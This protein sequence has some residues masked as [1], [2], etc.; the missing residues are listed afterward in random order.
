MNAS[1]AA[2]TTAIQIGTDDG[3]TLGADLTTPSHDPVGL[4]V[5]AHPHPL[6]G[7]NRFSPVVTAVFESLGAAGFAVIRF[8]FRGV[9][10]STGTHG[11]GVGERLDV[12]SVISD[13]ARRHPGVALVS[14]G[15]SFGARVALT[16]DHPAVVAWATVAPPLAVAPP[17][18]E[19]AAIGADQ[20][21]KLLIV[22]EQ[23]QFSPPDATSSAV[24]TWRA[25]EMVVSEGSDHF[26]HHDRARI[27]TAADLVTRFALRHTADRTPS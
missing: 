14:V 2:S 25:T 8:D 6:R 7:G 19:Q 10:T 13:L 23:D 27:T 26:F 1:N 11:N 5:V 3:E 18:P 22:P 16:V 20:R 15:Y 21:P 24:A 4:A 12:S 17:S 9:G